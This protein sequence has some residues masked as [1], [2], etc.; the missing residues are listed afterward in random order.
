VVIAGNKY[1]TQGVG[2]TDGRSNNAYCTKWQLAVQTVCLGHERP[3]G[4]ATHYRTLF[5]RDILWFC[6]SL[7]NEVLRSSQ[8]FSS[9]ATTLARILTAFP[10][11]A[12]LQYSFSA[13]SGHEGNTRATGER[14]K[15]WQKKRIRFQP[16]VFPLSGKQKQY[17][18]C[19]QEGRES[20]TAWCVVSTNRFI[21]PKDSRVKGKSRTRCKRDDDSGGTVLSLLVM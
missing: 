19:G 6:V 7:W 11:A 2:I 15:G 1:N 21:W 8:F 17:Y 12:R 16:S 5:L 13:W 18:W 4:L 20:F 14:R 10:I 3:P 9:C